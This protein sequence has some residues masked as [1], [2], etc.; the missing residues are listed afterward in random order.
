MAADV[1]SIILAVTVSLI[2]LMI[3]VTICSNF[4]PRDRKWCTTIF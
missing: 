2:V 4:I 3:T 1:C